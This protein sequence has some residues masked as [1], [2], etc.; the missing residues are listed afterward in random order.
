MHTLN[1]TNQVDQILKGFNI[2][3][4]NNIWEKFSAKK[5][6]FGYVSQDWKNYKNYMRSYPRDRS[7]S[8]SR[9]TD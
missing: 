7:L 6:F 8:A 5:L 2:H 3:F 1:I 9:G 4:D